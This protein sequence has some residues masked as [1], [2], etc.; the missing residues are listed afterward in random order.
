MCIHLFKNVESFITFISLSRIYHKITSDYDARIF[1]FKFLEFKDY[2]DKMDSIKHT[3][4]NLTHRYILWI[5]YHP[6]QYWLYSRAR[7]A[8]SYERHNELWEFILLIMITIAIHTRQI[9]LIIYRDK[10]KKRLLAVDQNH[11][12][13][14]HRKKVFT[15]SL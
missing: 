1:F 5:L 6:F 13:K 8:M 14:V 11:Y 15:L 12:Y 10:E 4:N 7:D 9:R 2:L 3:A